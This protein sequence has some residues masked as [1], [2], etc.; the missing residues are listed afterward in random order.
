MSGSLEREVKFGGRPGFEMPD[1]VGVLPGV[2]VVALPSLDLDATYYDTADLRLV[3]SGVSLR[4][5]TGEGLPTWTLKLPAGTSG[6]VLQRREFDIESDATEVPAELARLVTGWTRS[7]PLVAV[8]DILSRRERFAL[9]DSGGIDLAELDDDRVTVVENGVTAATFREIELELT[10]AGT[11]ALLGSV[12]AALLGAGAG[13]PDPM[14]K[15]ARALGPRALVPSPLEAPLPG[16]GASIAEV[17]SAA[18]RAAV[19]E[20]IA[21]DHVIR[22]DDDSMGLH[23]ARWALRRIRSDLKTF[24]GHVDDAYLDHLRTE[25]RWLSEEFGTLRRADVLVESVEF[26]TSSARDNDVSAV[27]RLID[28]ARSERQLAH[29][30]VIEILDSKRYVELLDLLVG[31]TRP[32][33]LFVGESAAAVEV[34]PK[35]LMRV[36]K[37]VRSA[38]GDMPEEPSEN[39]IRHVR[40]QII[41]LRSATELAV[42]VFGAAARDF[43]VL[44]A[45][46]QH[47]LGVHLDALACERWLRRRVDSLE[48]LEPFVAGQLVAAQSVI[49]DQALRAWLE[50][51]RA[52]SKR[53]AV[54]WFRS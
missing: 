46:A 45:K 30:S 29:E 15:V 51:W 42:P 24:T 37:R 47:D 21:N 9:V 18:L 14:S 22:L 27:E 17:L 48:G 53:S 25:L 3:R 28:R 39:D 34:I 12:T 26:A 13:A 19:A 16:A 33:A 31:V 2:S 54:A 43:A 4:R 35:A 20:V 40:R 5:R 50:S 52:C 32:A 36:W 1:L 11:D 8:I 23:R 49:S 38:V 44:T 41:R 7:E 10:D 6:S